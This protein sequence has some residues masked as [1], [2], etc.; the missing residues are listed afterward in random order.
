ML[1]KSYSL[2]LLSTHRNFLY[3][4]AAM[5]IV[6]CHLLT[7]VPRI[8]VLFPLA[9]LQAHGMA[10]VEIFLL[11]S[12]FGLYGSLSRNPDIKAFYKKRLARV[13]L[14]AFIVAVFFCALTYMSP[15]DMLAAITIIPFFWTGKSF[16]YVAFILMMYALY[17]LIYRLQRRFPRGA[18]LIF[19]GISAVTLAALMLADCE[20]YHLRALTRIPVFLLGCLIAPHV[21]SGKRLPGWTIFAAVL[22]FAALEAARMSISPASYPLRAV[23]FIPLALLV[24][25]L[26]ALL[27]D[28]LA[29]SAAGK[30]LYRMFA[31]AGGI[32]LEIYLVQERIQPLLL[33]ATGP[34]SPDRYEL[35]KADIASVILTVILGYMVSKLAA[36]LGRDYVNTK[37]PDVSDT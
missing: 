15:G 1:K 13:F 24:S 12:G 32:S 2:G 7:S 37:I 28:R 8:G 9:W 5:W 3:G 30:A 10:G 20:I 29:R 19:G 21:L 18:W 25:V 26:C 33:R 27:A 23:A 36:S 31:F 35:V 14:P 6:L 17:P 22:A 11:L 4:V 16:W 34:A